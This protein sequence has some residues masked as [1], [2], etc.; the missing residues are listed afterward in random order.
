MKRTREQQA[1]EVDKDTERPYKRMRQ[2]IDGDA[3]LDQGAGV[4]EIWALFTRNGWSFDWNPE[5]AKRTFARFLRFGPRDL[6]RIGM[7]YKSWLHSVRREVRDMFMDEEDLLLYILYSFSEYAGLYLDELLAERAR[8]DPLVP[9]KAY[10]HTER[11][12]REFQSIERDRIQGMHRFSQLDTKSDVF[13]VDEVCHR[14]I[15]GLRMIMRIPASSMMLMDAFILRKAMC[16]E[17]TLPLG[18]KEAIEDRNITYILGCAIANHCQYAYGAELFRG[19]N[20]IFDD[21]VKNWDTIHSIFKSPEQLL[22]V[23]EKLDRHEVLVPEPFKVSMYLAVAKYCGAAGERFRKELFRLIFDGNLVLKSDTVFEL[24]LDYVRLS[25]HPLFSMVHEGIASV[26][27]SDEELDRLEAEILSTLEAEILS[28]IEDT[29]QQEHK[30]DGAVVEAKGNGRSTPPPEIAKCIQSG[31]LSAGMSLVGIYGTKDIT[32]RPCRRISIATPHC[33]FVSESAVR[34]LNTAINALVGKVVSGPF[35]PRKSRKDMESLFHLCVAFGMISAVSS[36]CTWAVDHTSMVLPKYIAKSFV[37]QSGN[38]STKEATL[39][40]SNVIFFS[41]EVPLETYNT[42]YFL[43]EILSRMEEPGKMSGL[44]R[45]WFAKKRLISL[46]DPALA[47]RTSLGIA[48]T[49]Y[50]QSM[51]PIELHQW[52][53]TKSKQSATSSSSSSSSLALVRLIQADPVVNLIVEYLEC[54]FTEWPA[55]YRACYKEVRQMLEHVVEKPEE[56]YDPLLLGQGYYV[57]PPRVANDRDARAAPGAPI[58]N[59]ARLLASALI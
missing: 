30:K 42:D 18:F 44:Y 25:D 23:A 19:A 4:D 38:L 15:R 3:L 37:L 20:F 31:R 26:I 40:I 8:G 59:P 1:V 50:G 17:A 39:R 34:S 9:S 14:A 11:V 48:Y 51:C 41:S 43:R 55:F 7:V 21:C 36:L 47:E 2:T 32:L 12:A 28:T 16:R 27:C 5:L 56:P 33:L 6:E 49:P 58:R 35:G 53:E 46:V 22:A 52:D 13:N 10:I 24:A 57:S 54:P 45:A 29:K